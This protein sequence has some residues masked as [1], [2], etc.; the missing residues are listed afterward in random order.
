MDNIAKRELIEEI[1][2]QIYRNSTSVTKDKLLTK[3]GKKSI[4]L[5]YECLYLHTIDTNNDDKDNKDLNEDFNLKMSLEDRKW[6]LQQELE[7]IQ[8]EKKAN[9]QRTKCVNQIFAS[10]EWVYMMREFEEYIS[11]SYFFA[12]SIESN[13]HI[14]LVKN[15]VKVHSKPKSDQIEEISPSC[16]TFFFLLN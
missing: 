4:F 6:K 7:T 14:E 12:F 5:Q 3:F 2:K 11:D 9:D 15:A 16:S 13:L 1:N 8:K 10:R